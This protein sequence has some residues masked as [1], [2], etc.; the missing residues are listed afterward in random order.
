MGENLIRLAAA[1]KALEETPS[2]A[3]TD[4][5]F[6]AAVGQ[7]A[8]QFA[9]AFRQAHPVLVASEE[10]FLDFVRPDLP[11]EILPN[12]A[13]E[14]PRQAPTLVHE[15]ILASQELVALLERLNEAAQTNAAATRQFVQA[16]LEKL[17][18][19]ATS[20]GWDL[21]GVCHEYLS[22]AKLAGRPPALLDYMGPGMAGL[23]NDMAGAARRL[24]SARNA[25][26]RTGQTLA[27]LIGS[28]AEVSGVARKASST[29]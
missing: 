17:V 22:E 29:A 18:E 13:G 1:L 6:G 28:A 27:G 5:A 3:P 25:W 21:K 4:A 23:V 2:A 10:S 24:R 7:L 9:L 20:T 12:A 11:G 16:S 14:N 19:M 15:G 26:Y 8:R